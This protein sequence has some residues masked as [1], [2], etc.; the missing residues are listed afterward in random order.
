VDI[1][2]TAGG[3][4]GER[5]YGRSANEPPKSRVAKPSLD[6]MGPGTDR[7]TP[8]LHGDVPRPQKPDMMTTNF[9]AGG[10]RQGPKRR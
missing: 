8:L 2:R 3:Y 4:A 10:R 6:D 9:R 1:E 5:R 7:A